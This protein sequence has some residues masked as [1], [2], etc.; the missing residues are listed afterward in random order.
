MSF[1][2]LYPVDKFTAT[3]TYQ[4]RPTDKG[5][6]WTKLNDY[7]AGWEFECVPA[8]DIESLDDLGAAVELAAQDNAFLIR[9]TLTHHAR[10]MLAC[11]PNALINRRKEPKSDRDKP[12][13]EECRRQ[14]AMADLDGYRVPDGLSI[15]DPDDHEAIIDRAIRETMHPAFHEARAFFHWSSSTAMDDPTWVKGHIFFWL[16][17]AHENEAIRA[18]FSHHMPKHRTRIDPAVFHGV[19]PH[20]I[21]NPNLIGRSDPLPTRFGFR[22]G[23]LDEVTL[24]ALP[25]PP[26]PPK[27]G[28]GGFKHNPNWLDYAIFEIGDAEG[29]RGFHEPVRDAIWKYAAKVAQGAVKRNDEKLIEVLQQ[30]I[31]FAPRDEMRPISQ[32]EDYASD[33]RLRREIAEAMRKRQNQQTKERNR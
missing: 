28:E 21:A 3:K 25:P 4:W 26:P 19:Q 11:N 16:S 20:F 12:S 8:E 14:W 2:I 17:E 13:I 33:K 15:F 32:I 6:F 27:P 5:G 30:A 1:L 7:D 10:R 23:S 29:K 18:I 24:P 31:V 9:G 22:D